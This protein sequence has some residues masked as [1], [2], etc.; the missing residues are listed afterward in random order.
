MG[1]SRAMSTVL[2]VPEVAEVIDRAAEPGQARLSLTRL[3]DA[4]PELADRLASDRLFASALVALSDASRSLS[5]AVI[6]DVGLLAPLDDP[7]ELALELPLD[8]YTARAG[9]AVEDDAEDPGRGLRRWKRRELLRIAVRDLLGMAELP[10]VGRE[11]ASLAEGCLQ[12]AL[13]IAEARAG[14]GGLRIAVIGMGKLGGRELNY[15]SDVDV[16]FVHE[17]SSRPAE[18]VAR[19]LLT[20]MAQPT[21]YG[22]VFRTDADLRPEGRAGSLSRSL[23][24]YR[25]YW[26][27]WASTWEFQALIKARPVAG[28]AD[29][30]RAFIEAAAPHVWPERLDPDAVR[31]IRMMKARAEEE[32]SKRG[33]TDREIKRGRGGLRDIEFAVQL[34]QLVHGRHDPGIRSPNTLEALEELG[35]AGY[36]DLTQVRT[37]DAAY[38]FLRTVEHRL[39]LAEEA[40]VHSLPSDTAGRTHL[41]R[42]L[43]YRDEGS[44]TA[45]A[46]FET[47]HR[48]HQSQ[49]RSIHEKL[50]FRPLLEAIAGSGPL[51]PQAVEDRLA[52]F[53]FLDVA[54]T[55]AALA[56]LTTGLSRRSQLMTQLFPLLLEWLSEAPD[57]DLGLLQL[58]RLAE[59]R[60]RSG[61][62]AVAFREAPG[63]AERV[64]RLLGSSRL[65]GDALRRHPEFVPFLADNDFLARSKSREELEE[66]ALG[67]LAW[68]TGT[69]ERQEGVRRFKRREVLRIA[70]RDLLGFASV[71]QI[72][73]DLANLADACV[74]AT[75]RDLAPAVPFAV[76]G[77]GR[78]GGKELSYA[79]DIDV[80]FVY[81][82]SGAADFDGAEKTATRIISGIGAT[83]AEGQTFRIDANLRP[84]GKQG[85]LARSL[86]GYRTY[87]D[88][89]ALTWEFQSL[90]KARPVAGD[91][92]LAERFCAM[93]EPYVYRDP[94]PPGAIREVRRMKARIERE[95]IPPGEDPQ[96]HLK[97]GRGSLSDVEWTV[98]LLQLIHGAE[99]PELR[100]AST[101]DGL[102][103]L[104]ARGH[105][106]SADAEALELAYRFCERARNLRYL[107]TGA[108]GDSLPTDGAEAERLARLMG[109]THRPVT[110]LRDDYRRLTRRARAVVERVFYGQTG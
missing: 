81:D 89:W 22:I 13:R 103:R 20:T 17:G 84:E 28:D 39:Q 104:A 24:A 93:V 40:Q 70:S 59:G 45:V 97:L 61:A 33:L 78:L 66:E 1:H 37:L 48:R 42:V 3:L 105:L 55:R 95:R 2:K 46:R 58:R 6:A 92:A 90:L 53:G 23:D 43:G 31:E 34:L 4:H 57:P 83:T 98:Q 52:A 51:S 79:S 67:T 106:D 108:P 9:R 50:F 88:K 35:Q 68:R 82:G 73:E 91:L 74:E 47:T 80:L 76:I 44:S 12:A 109:Y 18:R 94:F 64:C 38:R 7:D 29:L 110:Q 99:D 32:V 60:A 85:P 101:V 72:A 11:L 107:L 54:H 8:D 30:G 102:A 49:V 26:D 25:T 15:S 41:A 21:P 75:L 69:D 100:T 71:E 14:G 36:V 77:V 87:Y 62:L 86:D 63:A 10:A 19:T 16:L 5:E 27:K 96:F 65:V 56:E